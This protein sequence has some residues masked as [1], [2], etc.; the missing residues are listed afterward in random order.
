MRAGPVLTPLVLDL[1][2]CS[3]PTMPCWH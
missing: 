2:S 3:L 1:P